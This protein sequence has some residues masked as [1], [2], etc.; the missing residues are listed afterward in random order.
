MK[1]NDTPETLQERQKKVAADLAI[2]HWNRYAD[3]EDLVEVTEPRYIREGEE[4]LIPILIARSK[5]VFPKG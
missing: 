1:A 5:I 3:G 2:K 4:G